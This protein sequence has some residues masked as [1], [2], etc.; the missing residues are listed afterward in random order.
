MGHEPVDLALLQAVI[1]EHPVDHALQG[2]DGD[3]ENFVALH[4]Q[5][6]FALLLDS[7]NAAVG[8]EQ[9]P[10]T[11]VGAQIGIENAG[12]IGGFQHHRA[13]A[14]AEQYARFPIGPVDDP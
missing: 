4:Q 12:I 13:G 1:L 10:V 9:I 7:R 5:G 3:L 2:A 11:A 6:R 8:V 14:V